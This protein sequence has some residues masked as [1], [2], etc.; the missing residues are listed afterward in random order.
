MHQNHDNTGSGQP[1]KVT[2]KSS[3]WKWAFDVITIPLFIVG[4]LAFQYFE[5]SGGEDERTVHNPRIERVAWACTFTAI[6]IKVLLVAASP[7]CHDTIKNTMTTLKCSCIDLLVAFY[8]LILT[9]R[10]A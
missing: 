1:W 10:T 6:S 8:W 4:A 3:W 5:Y 9:I 2:T 7:P